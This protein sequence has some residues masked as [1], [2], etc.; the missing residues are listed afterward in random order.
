M[1][2]PKHS[3]YEPIIRVLAALPGT[4]AQ[5]Q[6]RVGE[7]IPMQTVTD[8]L[9]SAVRTGIA[10][11]ERVEHVGPRLFARHYA[12]GPGPSAVWQHASRDGGRSHTTVIALATLFDALRHGPMVVAD[13]AD[14]T[15]MDRR[16]LHRTLDLL[17][18]HG[19]ARV[20]QWPRDAYG[21]P[22]AAW[23]LG[24]EPDIRKPRPTPRKVVN[25]RAWA[26]R[27]DKLQH[28]RVLAALTGSPPVVDRRVSGEG[29]AGKVS[30]QGFGRN[31]A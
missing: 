31:G 21:R 20:A 18:Q 25:A 27:R 24:S 2:R 1:A 14:E 13:L 7:D 3:G 16:V 17:R 6:Q 28:R 5:V 29:F 26:R 30:G 11:I 4:D 23:S 9:R 8:W 12:L 10:R 19:M 15:G 22:A